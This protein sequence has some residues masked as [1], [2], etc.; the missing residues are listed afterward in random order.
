[1]MPFHAVITLLALGMSFGVLAQ[2]SAPVAPNLPPEALEM[3]ERAPRPIVCPS[4]DALCGLIR[5][6]KSMIS[7]K[8]QGAI[9][10][11]VATLDK[12]HRNCV[13]KGQIPIKEDCDAQAWIKE[14]TAQWSMVTPQCERTILAAISAQTQMLDALMWKQDQTACKR[15]RRE[16]LT[17]PLRSERERFF[18]DGRDIFVATL[19]TAI[20]QI[21]TL[22]EALGSPG[23]VGPD[24]PCDAK[25]QA[26][27]EDHLLDKLRRIAEQAQRL[28]K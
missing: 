4:A 26:E 2:T 8:T 12:A 24:F 19:L 14:R 9:A 18:G 25:T 5:E 10:T 21:S 15:L 22:Q 16:R 20:S 23:K 11:L 1:M 6:G 27:V 28:R 3:I 13:G 7:G 17:V